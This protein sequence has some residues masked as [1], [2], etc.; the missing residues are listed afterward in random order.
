VQDEKVGTRQWLYCVSSTI[1]AT[2]LH[3]YRARIEVLDD[4][5][6]WPRARPDAGRALSKADC[7]KN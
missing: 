7:L 6:D 3:E 4:G 2:E 5:A 1:I